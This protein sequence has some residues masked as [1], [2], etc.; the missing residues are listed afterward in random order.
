[1]KWKS[2]FARDVFLFSLRMSSVF[3]ICHIDVQ[4][5]SQILVTVDSTNIDTGNRDRTTYAHRLLKLPSESN[6]IYRFNA[7][8]KQYISADVC[9]VME[10]VG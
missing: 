4:W 8:T 9:S 10:Y 3:F 5:N 1:M 6:V 2:F 7:T